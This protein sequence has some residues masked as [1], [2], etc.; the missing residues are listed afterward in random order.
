[1]RHTVCRLSNILFKGALT[2][3]LGKIFSCESC[4]VRSRLL[5]CEEKLEIMMEK[6]PTVG[7]STDEN[8]CYKRP[9][10]RLV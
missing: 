10:R 5:Q 6:C 1:M 4:R 9:N 3:P 2:Q 8:I 7:M